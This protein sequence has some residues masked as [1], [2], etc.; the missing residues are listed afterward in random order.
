ML[1][2]TLCFLNRSHAQNVF[3]EG[4]KEGGRQAIR[5]AREL[6]LI[7]HLLC[8]VYF[9]C[10]IT[11]N[12]SVIFILQM[13]VQQF[14]DRNPKAHRQYVVE[15]IYDPSLFDPPYLSPYFLQE[16][17]QAPLVRVQEQRELV[18]QRGSKSKPKFVQEWGDLSISLDKVDGTPRL[19]EIKD[20]GWDMVGW[21]VALKRNDI[22]G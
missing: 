15:I 5:M 21:D 18:A 14:R 12:Y 9:E 7:Q 13:K 20:S 1:K 4:K 3:K 16:E 8:V 11:F 6:I 2:P 19:E 17:N 10:I 22:H